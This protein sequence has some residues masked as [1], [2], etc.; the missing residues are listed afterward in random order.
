MKASR[1]NERRRSHPVELMHMIISHTRVDLLSF[2]LLVCCLCLRVPGVDGAGSGSPSSLVRCQWS[3]RSVPARPPRARVVLPSAS[4]LARHERLLAAAECRQELGRPVGDA[5]LAEERETRGPGAATSQP[6]PVQV[7]PLTLV[8]PAAPASPPSSVPVS[9]R[10]RSAS[11]PPSRS[12][13]W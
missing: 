4:S 3:A 11:R 12:S 1:M 10:T 2:V 13:R 9:V 7:A 6:A 8:C 5:T